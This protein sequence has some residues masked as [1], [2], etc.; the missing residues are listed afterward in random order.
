MTAP[1]LT[2]VQLYRVSNGKARP[3]AFTLFLTREP[4]IMD[5]ILR[6]GH[7]RCT[8]LTVALTVDDGVQSAKLLAQE[9]E[10]CGA[11]CAVAQVRAVMPDGWAEMVRKAYRPG[12]LRIFEH[13]TVA[14]GVRFTNVTSPEAL[15]IVDRFVAS[16]LPH[17]VLT[18]NVDHL[19]RVATDPTFRAAYEGADMV[20]VDGVP[21]MWAA[22]LMGR[23]LR[24]KLSGSDLLPLISGHAARKGY[25]V[26]LFGAAPGVAEEAAARLT[27]RN[28]GLQVAGTYSPPIGFEKDPEENARAVAAIRSAD[29]DI[30]FVAMGAPRQETWIHQNHAAC[31]ARVML[32]VGAS[33]DF[34]AGRVRRAPRVLQN[35]GLEWLWRMAQEPRRLGKRYL[36]DDSVFLRIVWEEW[37]RHR[38]RCASLRVKHTPG[39]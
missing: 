11:D 33:L 19:C 30:C 37:R 17:Y 23:P 14:F 31:G 27:E 35:A 34:A 7:D 18:P 2:P 8:E 26:F 24:E 21:V 10:R 25:R 15:G 32:G 39:T 20:A 16:G 4:I 5:S 29:P 12:R 36:V 38:R 9:A 13:P 6:D 28:P 22:R 1:A 3:K